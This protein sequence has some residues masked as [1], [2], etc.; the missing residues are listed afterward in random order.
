MGHCQRERF[1]NPPSGKGNGRL[2]GSV[3]SIDQQASEQ[4]TAG[5]F[6]PKHRDRI[7]HSGKTRESATMSFRS[8]VDRF[9]DP[10]EHRPFTIPHC[11]VEKEAGPTHKC[12]G[13]P[14]GYDA[15]TCIIHP[16]LSG[17]GHGECVNFGVGIPVQPDPCS[18][19]GGCTPSHRQS[20]ARRRECS[21]SFL[22]TAAR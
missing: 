18:S 6:F 11:Q 5:C 3:P 14:V 2:V 16:C 12:M 19:A 8:H 15:E 4:K 10:I 20:V 13:N 1:C 7:C 21:S 9:V 22:L 17:Q